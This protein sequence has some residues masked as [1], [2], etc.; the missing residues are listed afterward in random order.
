MTNI[1]KIKNYF[2][3]YEYIE[4]IAEASKP[5]CARYT[6]VNVW[7]NEVIWLDESDLVNTVQKEYKLKKYQFY[8]EIDKDNINIDELKKQF[9]DNI[10]AKNLEMFGGITDRRRL[11]NLTC[12]QLAEWTWLADEN[13]DMFFKTYKN[14][15]EIYIMYFVKYAVVLDENGNPIDPDIKEIKRA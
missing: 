4:D 7:G 12:N 5:F 2:K 15:K 1:D 14:G 10:A 3:S 9:I 6:S 11:F 8:I 13:G